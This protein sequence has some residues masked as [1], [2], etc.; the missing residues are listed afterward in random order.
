VWNL[1][2][3][4]GGLGTVALTNYGSYTSPLP[5]GMDDSPGYRRAAHRQLRDEAD[6]HALDGPAVS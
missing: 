1:D 6:G 4:T 2:G 3:T 5:V